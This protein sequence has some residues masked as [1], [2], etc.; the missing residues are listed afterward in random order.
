ML[1]TQVKRSLWFIGYNYFSLSAKANANPATATTGGDANSF[2]GS[3][4]ETG[5]QIGFRLANPLSLVILGKVG[6]LLA[7]GG[8]MIPITGGVGLRLETLGPVTL[9]AGAGYNYTLT[10][11][12]NGVNGNNPNPSGLELFGGPTVAISTSWR[13]QALVEYGS[14]SGSVKKPPT[15]LSITL[16]RLNLGFAVGF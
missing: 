11:S 3:G 6:L 2:S 7:D 15:D 10:L 16:F 4:V 1:P 13:L 5:L 9:M 12:D 14:L 8:K